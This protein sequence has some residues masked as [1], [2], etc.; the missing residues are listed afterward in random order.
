MVGRERLTLAELERNTVLAQWLTTAKPLTIPQLSLW[1]RE[2]AAVTPTVSR[3]PFV[4]DNPLKE[5]ETVSDD[6]ENVQMVPKCEPCEREI[7]GPSGRFNL[8]I[9]PCARWEGNSLNVRVADGGIDGVWITAAH[10]PNP[11]DP[12]DEAEGVNVLLTRKSAE[13]I[14]AM[15][16]E[17]LGIVYAPAG[18]PKS[19]PANSPARA[20]LARVRRPAMSARPED[21]IAR[22][23]CASWGS[24]FVGEGDA[25]RIL[26]A[27]TAAGFVVVPG[28]PT[29][30]MQKA[31]WVAVDRED[32]CA[33]TWDG[34]YCEHCQSDKV[35]RGGCR[36]LAVAAYRAMLAANTKE[37]GDE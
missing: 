14:Y 16:G 37:T 21:V 10:D 28:E 29:E 19:L 17:W 35:K 18:A 2:N 13:V 20:A 34:H 7:Y 33:G 27:L 1:T 23:L 25:T 15:L 5:N 3:W 12:D 30:A 4:N 32:G 22:A 26:A 36:R 6:A 8:V 24:G 31:G 9:A 11:D